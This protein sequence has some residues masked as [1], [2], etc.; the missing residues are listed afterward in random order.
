MEAAEKTSEVDLATKNLADDAAKPEAK[1]EFGEPAPSTTTTTTTT[2]TLVQSTTTTVTKEAAPAV[3]S[4]IE[5]KNAAASALAAAAVKAR[6]LALNEEK[7][8]KSTVSLLVET[9]LKKLEIKLKHFEELEGIMDRERENLE[10]QRQQLLQERQQF[11]LEQLRAAEYR[12]RQLAA[13]QHL[14]DG[15]LK[16]PTQP[17][18]LIIQ[19]QQTPSSETPMDASSSVAP[20]PAI[21][22]QQPASTDVS[23]QQQPALTHEAA[24][25]AMAAISVPVQPAPSIPVA[26]VQSVPAPSL[27]LQPQQAHQALTTGV[28]TP[29]IH[30]PQQATP[31]AQQGIK[32]KNY[33]LI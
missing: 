27:V 28:A 13:Q 25:S 4:E 10:H 30:P 14:N 21:Q 20:S 3:I 6:Q 9:Q 16:V 17:Q 15:K 5:L 1:T 19:Q 18:R 24:N 32:K 22:Q 23:M 11:H 2:T 31:E 8:I 33:F 29:D 26:E 12:Q 7:K